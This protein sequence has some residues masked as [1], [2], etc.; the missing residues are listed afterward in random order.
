MLPLEVFNVASVVLP[1]NAASSNG[2]QE[3]PVGDRSQRRYTF[4]KLSENPLNPGNRQIAI[5]RLFD[6]R[7]ETSVMINPGTRHL[8][9][10]VVVVCGGGLHLTILR[11]GRLAAEFYAYKLPTLPPPHLCLSSSVGANRA[12]RY[13]SLLN[14]SPNARGRGR[15]RSG[16]G[17]FCAACCK[18]Y[19]A[20]WIISRHEKVLLA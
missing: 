14:A 19:A 13:C 6:I 17:G 3:A 1:K 15:R 7:L 8:P 9:E 2:F 18:T 20:C 12:D 11:D 10:V 5:V 16:A 4:V